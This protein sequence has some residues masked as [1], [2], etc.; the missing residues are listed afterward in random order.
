MQSRAETEVAGGKEEG[1]EEDARAVVGFFFLA[2]FFPSSRWGGGE[3]DER[4]E[5]LQSL[6]RATDPLLT[7]TARTHTHTNCRFP[8][9]PQFQRSPFLQKKL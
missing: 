4:R 2:L 5:E 7:Y 1:K 9:N 6:A 8:P 3:K